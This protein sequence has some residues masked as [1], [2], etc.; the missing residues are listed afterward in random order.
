MNS[1]YSREVR[2]AVDIIDKNLTEKY[3]RVLLMIKDEIESGK[4]QWKER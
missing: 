4:D 3:L 2:K 1:V